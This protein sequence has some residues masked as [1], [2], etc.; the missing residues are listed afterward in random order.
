MNTGLLWPKSWQK[1]SVKLALC[2]FSIGLVACASAPWLDSNEAS[3]QPPTQV[4]VPTNPTTIAIT[5]PNVQT[6][7]NEVPY[8]G[9]KPVSW[10][11]LPGL[12]QEQWVESWPVWLQSCQGLKQK[13]EWREVCSLALTVSAK[14]PQAIVGYWQQYFQV[15]ATSQADGRDQGLI[16]GYYQPV[17]KG[18]KTP[19]IR[20]SI[21]LYKTPV[22]LITV[23]LNGLFPELKYKRVRGRI[24]GQSLVPYYTRA[25]IERA[26]SPL[27]GQELVWV[28]DAVE[29]FFLQVQGSGMVELEPSGY[30]H[31]GYA[32]QNG[33]P[34]QSIGRLLVERGEM[35]ASEASMQTIKA[36]GKAHPTQLRALL[37]A[38][39]SYVF[40]KELPQGLTGPLGALGVPLTAGRSVAV[41]PFYVPLGAPYYL[42][43]T[44]P[45]QSQ[46][47]QQLMMAQDTGGAIKGGVRADVYWGAG[48]SA[49]KMAG[50]M[51]QTGQAWVWLP[52]TMK[53]P[54]AVAH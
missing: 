32:D 27:Q 21:P 29:A 10:A 31:V 36:W 46:P 17:L 49:G 26:N 8:A 47:L 45:N 12:S 18:A 7:V 39:P 50:A 48:E 9:L 40:F 42:V 2:F 51:R 23:S 5:S 52:K 14:D 1:I 15:Y 13:A 54:A 19:T 44:L 4:S 20:Y 11:D 6:P 30:M 34:Y 28:E 3:P 16:T 24:Q 37:D 35:T 22:D 33:H 41:D 25:E 43:T 38:N 53:L